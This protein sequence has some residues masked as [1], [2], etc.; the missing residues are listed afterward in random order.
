MVLL[1]RFRDAAWFPIGRTRYRVR[2]PSPAAASPGLRTASP[3]TRTAP[4]GGS[5]LLARLRDRRGQAMMEFVL[6]LGGL[7]GITFGGISLSYGFMAKSVVVAAARDAARTLA[8]DC[9][10]GNPTAYGDAE[11][12]AYADLRAGQTV[13]DQTGGATAP[14]PPTQGAWGFSASCSGS[15]A[16]AT[17]YYDAPTMFPGILA[18]AG[19]KNANTFQESATV[20]FPVE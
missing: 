11:A 7:L 12:A 3:G 8:I 9:G 15:L 19:V 20:S 2:T 1:Q 6:I 10:A 13:V 18:S 5:P 4:T 14:S 17:V 16:T